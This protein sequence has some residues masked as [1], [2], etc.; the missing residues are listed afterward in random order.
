MVAFKITAA[1]RNLSEWSNRAVYVDACRT[2]VHKYPQFNATVYDDLVGLLSWWGADMD[3]VTMIGVLIGMGLSV[4]Y[5]AHTAHKFY[6]SVGT[7]RERIEQTFQEISAAMIQAS[8]S[9][10]LC[11][12]PLAFVATYTILILAKTVFLVVGLGLIHG[13]FIL[14][15]LLVTMHNEKEKNMSVNETIADS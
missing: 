4:D 3:P 8:I 10:V 5:T 15:I 6:I 9:T 7:P 2:V 11:M 1:G 14:P 12:L 13:I